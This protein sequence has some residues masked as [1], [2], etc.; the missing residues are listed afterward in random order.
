MT[1]D[2]LN[3]KSPSESPNMDAFQCK[4]FLRLPQVLALIPITVAHGGPGANQADTPSLSNWGCARRF[5]KPQTSLPWWKAFPKMRGQIQTH[6]H[7][8]QWPN[9]PRRKSLSAF[10]LAGF[11]Y[12]LSAMCLF[13]RRTAAGCETD[14]CSEAFP[15]VHATRH[16]AACL[17]SGMMD[18]S[19]CSSPPHLAQGSISGKGAWVESVCMAFQGIQFEKSGQAQP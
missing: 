14:H 13:Q 3:P 5:G 10:Q 8:G 2:S 6:E 4:G 17:P 1:P 11:F 18:S 19:C 7:I 12:A 9:I 15:Q 16:T